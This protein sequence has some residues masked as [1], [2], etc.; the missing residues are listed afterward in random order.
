MARSAC[1]A[2]ASL[3]SGRNQ[4]RSLMPTGS[5][6][7]GCRST[8]ERI[9]AKVVPFVDWPT[10]I[11]GWAVADVEFFPRHIAHVTDVQ[12]RDC[13]LQRC[14]CQF[15]A[16]TSSGKGSGVPR[17]KRDCAGAVLKSQKKDCWEDHLH[18]WGSAARSCRSVSSPFG[19][20]E[21]A[22]HFRGASKCLR[23]GQHP[24]RCQAVVPR[25]PCR[26]NWHNHPPK[27]AGCHRYRT[28]TS[29]QQ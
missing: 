7:M 23:S 12:P 14:G 2:R 5:G 16:S 20:G 1:P 19:P 4:Y 18:C 21:D 13:H 17:P 27:A 11:L 29:P 28:P 15:L 22:R 9:P 3:G 24:R 8:P 25:C 26:C 10:E 6:P